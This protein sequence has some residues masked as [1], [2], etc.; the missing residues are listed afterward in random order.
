MVLYVRFLMYV[1]ATWMWV[2]AWRNGKRVISSELGQK[3]HDGQYFSDGSLHCII[4]DKKEKEKEKAEEGK[5][6]VEGGKR[7]GREAILV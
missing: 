5:E 4:L 7:G 6:E 1:S 3:F 2:K